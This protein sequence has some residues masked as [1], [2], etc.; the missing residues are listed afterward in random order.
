MET[1]LRRLRY[2]RT[3]A[4]TL[5][6]R[7][8]SRDLNITQPALSRAIAQLEDELDVQLFERS[9]GRVKLTRAGRTFTIECD[10][11]LA[12]VESAMEET[13]R[14]ARGEIGSLAVGYTDTAMAGAIPDIIETFR[15]SSPGV[16]IRLYQVPTHA[17]VE[18]LRSGQLDV[19]VMTGPADGKIF[20]AVQVQRDRLVMLAPVD[21]PLA[22]RHS[23]RLSELAGESFVLGDQTDWSTYNRALLDLC[24]RAGFA[25]NVV[26]RA[27]ESQAIIGLVSCG[28]GVTIMPECHA[29]VLNARLA[30]IP[31]EEGM[32]P[33]V[34]EAVWIDGRD[35]PAL[36]RFGAHLARYDLSVTRA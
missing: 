32:E 33:M 22:A 36:S 15:Q 23:V 8:A 17:Q 24:E 19:G 14:V 35:H 13:R 18:M 29:R 9:T 2:F 10:R 7:A 4:E 28:L 12:T 3:V 34:T 26:Q 25:P 20:S 16:T 30:A 11:V 5:N 31:I 21:H 1:S 6:F 27:P